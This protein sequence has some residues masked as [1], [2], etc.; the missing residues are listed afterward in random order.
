[1]TAPK[2]PKSED[3]YHGWTDGRAA[4]FEGWDPTEE[5]RWVWPDDNPPPGVIRHRG[6]KVYLDERELTDDV[7]RELG[8]RV[9][10]R[11]VGDW[12]VVDP[13]KRRP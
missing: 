5:W 9:E 11:L 3:Y 12:H 10:Y 8:G 7:V 13:P 6:G 4:K 2:P 1:M